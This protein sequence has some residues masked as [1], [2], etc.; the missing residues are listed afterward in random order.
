MSNEQQG[1]PMASTSSH[2][3]A[4]GG[5][6]YESPTPPQSPNTGLV[7]IAVA[8]VVLAAGGLAWNILGPRPA[9]A[10][11]PA[12]ALMS[13]QARL[14]RDAV[15]MAREAQ[16]MQ[17]EHLARIEAEMRGEFGGAASVGGEDPW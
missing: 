13:E 3:P 10:P 17:R 9:P 15:Q 2:A 12:Q 8:G 11:A 16:Q 4:L 14:M 5:R 1:T 7:V 6:V